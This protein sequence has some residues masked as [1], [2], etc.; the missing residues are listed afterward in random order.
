LSTRRTPPLPAS[1]SKNFRSHI[2]CPVM[3]DRS[4]PPRPFGP[5]SAGEAIV[6]LWALDPPV[7]GEWRVVDSRSS[8]PI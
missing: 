1:V 4:M 5:N 3:A 7:G 6:G 8:T 2:Y